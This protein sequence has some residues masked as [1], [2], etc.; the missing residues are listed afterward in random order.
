MTTPTT[1]TPT[2]AP[3]SASD[4][5]QGGTL[6]TLAG[7]S[8]YAA[9]MEQ[10]GT[11][12]LGHLVL[13]SICET[14]VA[15]TDLERW[16]RQFG[17]DET[18]LP[19]PIREVDA[20][21]QVTGKRGVR[22]TYKLTSATPTPNGGGAVTGRRGQSGKTGGKTDGK[23]VA[24]TLMVRHVAR[25]DMKIVR[26]LVREVRDEGAS[27]LSY[28]TRLAEIVFWRDPAG[29]GRPGVGVLQI[30]PNEAAIAQLSE[31]EQAKV[32]KTLQE[33]EDTYREQCRFY[34]SDRLRSLVRTYIEGLNAVRVRPT[35]GV[36]FV[37][38]AHEAPLAAL[39]E[40][41]ARFGDGSHLTRVPL[42]DQEEM[43][44]MVVAA[45]T[46][47]TKED[48]DKLAADIAAARRDGASDAQMQVLLRRFQAL[49]RSTAEHGRLLSSSLDDTQA[50]LK[51]VNAQVTNLLAGTW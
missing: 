39:R 1:P 10:S 12:I 5:G 42:P 9:A 13:Y 18:F 34:N 51:L 40:L 29:T 33:V 30:H 11:P 24:V 8:A 3:A 25:D 46:T 16:F 2:P 38:R 23:T 20:Y 21:E 15:R 19:R 22:A 43:R 44:E 14:R 37:H 32:R 4:G 41:V 17:L 31:S 27:R 6:E 48:L 7:F 45:L 35:G 26:H 36:Y 28:D 49:Q 50:A 47:K